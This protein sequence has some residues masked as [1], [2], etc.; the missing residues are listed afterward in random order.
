MKLRWVVVCSLI[1]MIAG[2]VLGGLCFSDSQVITLPADTAFIEV[3]VDV[4]ITTTL[5]IHDTVVTTL[6]EYIHDTTILFDTIKIVEAYLGKVFYSKK[7][8]TDDLEAV[9]KDTI[10]QNRIISRQFSYK[11]LRECGYTPRLIIGSELHLGGKYG[12]YLTGGYDASTWIV[13]AGY[14]PFN[15]SVKIGAFYKF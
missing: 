12:L 5:Y 14:D 8:T 2:V 3:P 10:S 13:N 1:G 4:P 9:I 11:N 15:K 7:I 6:P